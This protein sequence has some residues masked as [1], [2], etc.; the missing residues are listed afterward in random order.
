MAKKVAWVSR[1]PMH[2]SQK[3][4]LVKV[5]GNDIII[6]GT[7]TSFGDAREIIKKYRDG[8]FDD[9]VIVAPLSVLEVLCSQGIY[10]LWA[11]SVEENDPA[12]IEFR[13]ARGQG[14]RFVGFKRIK[15]IRKVFYPDDETFA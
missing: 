11:D 3:E 4:A 13:G 15:E 6:D 12:K 9:M 8:K 14:F 7:M 10:P 5:Y 2:P 1:H